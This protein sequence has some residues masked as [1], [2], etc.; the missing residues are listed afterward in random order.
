MTETDWAQCDFD[1]PLTLL[2]CADWHEE[3]G[4]LERA[5]ALRLI[6]Q[7]GW[8]PCDCTEH[9]KPAWCWFKET[10][11]KGCG[12]Y[13]SAKNSYNTHPELAVVDS[14]V[15][16][17]LTGSPKRHGLDVAVVYSTNPEAYV[18]LLDVLTLLLKE[19]A[20]SA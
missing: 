8:K 14:L 2:V 4:Q 7:K 11:G 16:D 13:Q 15:F 5:Q 6:Q 3:Q 17:R 1:D 20:L 19:G 12:Y 18:E 9:P 10:S